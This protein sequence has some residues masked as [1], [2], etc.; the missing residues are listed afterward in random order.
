MQSRANLGS[1]TR[2]WIYLRCNA[3]PDLACV[4]RETGRGLIAGLC[5]HKSGECQLEGLYGREFATF[6]NS[7]NSAMLLILPVHCTLLVKNYDYLDMLGHKNVKTWG[8]WVWQP[9]R[10]HR[11]ASRRQVELSGW[12]CLCFS[13]LFLPDLTA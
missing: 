12:S 9:L 8:Q 1:S 10:L 5:K 2:A 11:A 4:R 13:L 6:R 7:A 3:T